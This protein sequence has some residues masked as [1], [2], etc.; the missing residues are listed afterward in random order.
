MDY[1]DGADFNHPLVV[2]AAGAALIL[3][4]AGFVLL[5]IRM[6]RSVIIWRA[7]RR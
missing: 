7:A 5:F 1:D 4:I 6:R 2:G 3:V